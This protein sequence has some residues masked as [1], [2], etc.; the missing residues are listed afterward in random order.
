MNRERA[1]DASWKAWLKENLER[2]C[3]RPEL[4]EILR[5]HGFSLSSIQQNMGAA[6]PSDTPPPGG[7]LEAPRLI[8]QPP[9]NL[10]KVDTSD[11]DLYTLDH[12]LSAKECD[13]LLALISHHLRPSTVTIEGN[14]KLFRTSRTCDLSMLR[15][16]VA[17]AIDAK[18]TRTLGIRPEYSEGIQAQRYD[19]G[20]QFKAHTDYFEPGTPEY[21]RFGGERGNRTWTFMVYLNE[22]MGGGGT[23]FVAID[24][25]FQPSKGQAVIWNN[26][27][28]DG[29]PNAAT[30]HSG[31]PVTAG[32][33]VI[34]TKWFRELGSGPM[35]YD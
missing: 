5:G 4:V 1:L 10:H 16:P 26:L 20:Q 21:A 19:V 9:A 24:H 2:G 27:N 17:Q 11:L 6:F 15:S 35:F 22:G 18:I 8:R 14:D 23:R 29:T 3:R 31:E 25:A 13:R 33:K 7:P 34:I 30:L 28:P 12:F 32:Q